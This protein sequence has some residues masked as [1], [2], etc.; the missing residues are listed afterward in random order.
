MKRM[1]WI[2]VVAG[3]LLLM[4]FIPALG[5]SVLGLSDSTIASDS[6]FIN[7]VQETEASYGL[8][9]STKQVTDQFD[10]YSCDVY[11]PSAY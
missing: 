5:A 8:Q 6:A 9:T 1:T 4:V 11:E 3:A 10:G 2:P 7:L